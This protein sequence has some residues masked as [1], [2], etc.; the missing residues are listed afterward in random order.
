[1]QDL[2]ISIFGISLT[3]EFFKNQLI[4]QI[5]TKNVG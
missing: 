4:W 3:P 1:M 2:K 5:L